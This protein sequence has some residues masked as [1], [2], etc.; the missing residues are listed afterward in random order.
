MKTLLQLFHS[1]VRSPRIVVVVIG[2]FTVFITMRSVLGSTFFRPHDF[3]HAARLAEMQRSLQAGEFPV[4]WSRNFGFG[5]GMPLFNF[6]APLPY[7]LGQIPL[8]LGIDAVTSIK[9]LYL[10]NGLL[11][12]VGMYL[13]AWKLWG[14]WGGL[15]S[16]VVFSFSTYRALDLFVRGALGEAYALVL[17]P[18]ALYGVGLTTQKKK[19]GILVTAV[20]LA[21]I[22]LSHNLTGMVAVGLVATYGLLQLLLSKRK[23]WS[24]QILSLVM[25]ILL[26]IGLGAFYILPAYFEKDLTR[27]DQTI[28]IGYFDYHNHFLCFS[29]IFKSQWKYGGSLPGCNDDL[30]FAFGLFAWALAAM[31]IL[32]ISIWGRKRDRVVGLILLAFFLLSLFLTLGKS[33]FI[34]EQIGIMKYFQFPW[35]FLTFSHVFFSLLT[36]GVVLL[37]SK[38]KWVWVLPAGLILAL[39]VQQSRFYLPEKQL[40]PEEWNEFYNTSKEWIRAE[41]SKTLNDYL[42]PSISDNALPTQMDARFSLDVG[43]LTIKEDTSILATATVTCQNSCRLNVNN[44]QY[45]GWKAKV[46]GRE[47]ELLASGEGLPIY[48]LSLE[49]GSHEVQVKYEGTVI[50]TFANLISLVSFFL[51]FG[52]WFKYKHEKIN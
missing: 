38:W 28:T 49:P 43:Q 31:G 52:L 18:F 51:A 26:A 50:Q 9:F 41:T 23:D 47:I 32:A 24:W 30:S 6:Y 34:W 29:Q 45:P 27:V 25:G 15:V 44:F 48:S 4:R 22:L 36:G 16:A 19:L 3:T 33:S 37:T 39:V 35:R 13:L 2:L 1:V 5:Y 14:K 21:A 20:S 7:Y 40:R 46:D 11:A 12:F 17:I 42:P 8:F 10:F